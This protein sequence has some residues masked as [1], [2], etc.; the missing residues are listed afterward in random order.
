MMHNVHGVNL[1]QG[2]GYQTLVLISDLP[3]SIST[4]TMVGVVSSLSSLG[5]PN[6]FDLG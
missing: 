3:P 5:T 2:F 6:P 4:I 1:S